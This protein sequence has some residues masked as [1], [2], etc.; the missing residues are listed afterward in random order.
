M[1]AA[2]EDLSM[3]HKY[4]TLQKDAR[5]C[6]GI[7]KVRVHLH[8]LAPTEGIP[9]VFVPGQH[10]RN[11]IKRTPRSAYEV[12]SGAAVWF[13]EKLLLT[14]D[15]ALPSQA[16]KIDEAPLSAESASLLS[17]CALWISLVGVHSF[18][19]ADE[20]VVARLKRL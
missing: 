8:S 15:A 18:F 19:C 13:N 17:V 10:S 5:F 7:M 4:E 14:L 3:E 12:P 2:L 16:E 9:G 1:E 6:S 11:C 20:V